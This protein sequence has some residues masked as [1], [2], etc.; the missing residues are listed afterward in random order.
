[1]GEF[2][3]NEGLS[4][5]DEIFNTKQATKPTLK[6]ARYRE[7]SKAIIVLLIMSVIPAQAGI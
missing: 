1:M 3:Q 2:F 5:R 7:R 4:L 6:Q